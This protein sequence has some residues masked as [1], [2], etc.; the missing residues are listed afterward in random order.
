MGMQQEGVQGTQDGG[1]VCRLA[2]GRGPSVG[3]AGGG[4]VQQGV[5]AGEAG[6]TSGSNFGP[7]HIPVPPVALVLEVEEG[8]LYRRAE[9]WEVLEA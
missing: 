2:G 7:L 8:A 5:V 6:S 3:G 9:A 4:I 1:P